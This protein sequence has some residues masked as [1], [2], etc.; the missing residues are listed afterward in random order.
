MVGNNRSRKQRNLP[1]AKLAPPA[2]VCV[3]S[4]PRLF[5]QIDQAREENAVVWITGAAGAGKTLLAAS[6]IQARQLPALWYRVDSGDADLASFFHYLRAAFRHLAPRRRPPPELSPEY[7]ADLPTFT[8]NFFRRLASAFRGDPGLL[9]F[10]NWHEL[11]PSSSLHKLFAVGLEELPANVAV[12]LLSRA[13]PPPPLS[14]LQVKGRMVCLGN[15]SLMMTPEEIASLYRIRTGRA[16]EPDVV[17]RLQDIT[18]GWAAGLALLLDQPEDEEPSVPPPIQD[19]G[20]LFDYF[21]TEVLDRA[22]P[23]V[24]DFLLSTAWLPVFT[25]AMARDIS[26]QAEVS[27]TLQQLTTG[28]YFTLQRQGQPATYEYHPLF[29][30][31][32]RTRAREALSGNERRALMARS[33]QLLAGDGQLQHAAWLYAE[34]SQWDELQGLIEQNAEELA[35][36]GRFATLAALLERLPAERLQES[37]DLA[38]WEG[39]AHLWTEPETARASLAR[40]FQQFEAR[41]DLAGAALAWSGLVETYLVSWSE[42]VTL[43]PWIEAAEKRLLPARDRLPAPVAARLSLALF[44]ALMYRHPG[45]DRLESLAENAWELFRSIDDEQLRLFIG[46]HLLLYF[47]WWAADFSAAEAMEEELA[48][49][50]AESDADPRIKL[51]HLAARS[52]SKWMLADGV[53]AMEAADA[54]LALAQREGVHVWD[55]FIASQGALAALAENLPDRALG[56]IEGVRLAVQPCRHVDTAWYRY[57]E[58]QYAEAQGNTSEAIARLRGVKREVELAGIPFFTTAV[59]NALGRLLERM[60]ETEEGRAL[61]DRAEKLARDIDSRSLIYIVA[62]SRAELA[63]AEAEDERCLEPLHEAMILTRQRGLVSHDWWRGETMACLAAVALRHG[64]EPEP[65]STA[66]RSPSLPEPRKSPSSCCRC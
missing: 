23:E 53:G 28:S 10:D 49:W 62:L 61:L 48:A 21:A 3:L 31:F 50:S 17:T 20:V 32:L 1:L 51:M 6:Y 55:V 38:Y 37:P 8:R 11:E 52:G 7:L 13:E 47:T 35:R 44:L 43:D 30:A 41:S 58:A 39:M 40:A 26:G 36:S 56:Y 5:A 18:L 24:H 15:D 12:L 60:G 14:A 42:F 29:A 45:D 19:Q 66:S 46:S 2:P 33:A 25:Q 16:P 34:L 64:I 9:V 22:E 54:G 59:Y 4:R 27:G 65:N 57:L 63:C